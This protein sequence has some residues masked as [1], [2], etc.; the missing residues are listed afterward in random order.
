[1]RKNENCSPRS[2]KGLGDLAQLDEL[3]EIFEAL[4]DLV[5]LQIVH[6]VFTNPK[7]CSCDLEGPTNKSQS[8]ISHHTTILS[9]VGILVGEKRG[10]WTYWSINPRI[11]GLIRVALGLGRQN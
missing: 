1:M 9:E 6:L 2:L 11:K 7:I 3:A 4:G 5:R 8:T 10:R